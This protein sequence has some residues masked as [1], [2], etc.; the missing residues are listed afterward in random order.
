MGWW[1]SVSWGVPRLRRVGGVGMDDV[2][3]RGGVYPSLEHDLSSPLEQFVQQSPRLA[4]TGDQPTPVVSQC[5]RRGR[6]TLMLVEESPQSVLPMCVMGFSHQV[7]D[8]VMCFLE[9]CFGEV[10]G[11]RIHVARILV[12]GGAGVK[13]M[14]NVGYEGKN[15]YGAKYV[16][17]GSRSRVAPD[18][19]GGCHRHRRDTTHAAPAL[20]HLATCVVSSW[21]PL[22]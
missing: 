14:C 4:R 5:F 18:G 6:A 19:R 3:P 21:A 17:G 11:R 13:W 1:K 12:V 7:R 15:W 2:P 16:E 8:A 10:C 20:R 22:P 9:I